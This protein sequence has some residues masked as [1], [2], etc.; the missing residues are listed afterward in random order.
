[1]QLTTPRLVLRDYVAAD[2]DALLAY[3]ADPRARAFYGPGE[4]PLSGMPDLLRTFLGWAREEPRRNWQLA[5]AR[6]EAPHHAIGSGGLRQGGAGA[7]RADLG[8]ELAPDAW[9]QGY[10][11][12]A[13]S[14]L[15]DF[16]F[17]ELGLVTIRGETVSANARVARLLQRLGFRRVGTRA[18]PDWMID[19]GWT[20]AEWELGRSD[21]AAGSRP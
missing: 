17:R 7:G 14:A 16:G 18:G 4:A 2:L 6:R 9:G 19:R 13:A 12:E 1:V 20:Y 11:A 15:V 5:I 8:L 3:Q 10:G 21:W